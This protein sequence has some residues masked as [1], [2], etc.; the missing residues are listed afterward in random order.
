MKGRAWS[1]R[2]TFRLSGGVAGLMATRKP[3]RAKSMSNIYTRIGVKPFINL[4][5]TYTINGGAL[6]L[7]EVKR[8]MDEASRYS[9]NLDELM[10]KV[11]ARLAELLGA[12]AA[13]VTSGCA[14][15]LAHST[16]AA[17]AGA[18]PEKMQRLPHLDGMRDQ[19]IMPKQSRNAY[20]H[21]FRSP[22]ATIIEIDRAEEF[23]NALSDRV[24]LVAVLGTGEPKGRIRLEEMV[25]AAHKR[26]IPVIVD[27]A[28]ELPFTP[29]PYLSRGATILERRTRNHDHVALLRR[30][31]RPVA[32][33]GDQRNAKH[34]HHDERNALRPAPEPA[35]APRR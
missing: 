28:A 14:A 18:D 8:A 16:A 31:Q 30:C 23:H 2:D 21:A 17:I 1:R 26:G 35:R 19:V 3:A 10:E 29:N 13:I 32:Q 22:G 15:A 12:E 11:G 33:H 4:T 6:T 27:A 24:A 9:V 34:K 5:A 25:A 7:P 20:D